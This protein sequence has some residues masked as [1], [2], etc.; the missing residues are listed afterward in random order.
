MGTVV[1][2]A[3]GGL[4]GVEAGGHARFLGI[5]YAA[6]P[7]TDLRW[8][9]PQPPAPWAGV[10][11]A[12]SFGPA[13][14]QPPLPAALARVAVD[15]RQSEDCLYLNV[16][17]PTS[18][19]GRKLPVM[20]WIHG[21]SYIIGSGA[22]PSYD[23][24]AFAR[25]EV[26]CVTLNYRLNHFGFFAHPALT[27]EDPA[28]PLANY[29]ILDQIQA[30]RWI[31]E[32]IAAFGGD[33]ENVTIFG[34]SAGATFTNLLMISPLATG[35]FK[36]AIVQSAPAFQRWRGM[37]HRDG[38]SK[39]ERMGAA[40]AAANG[41]PDADASALRALPAEAVLGDPSRIWTANIGP[42]I[43]GVI[44]P[45]REAETYEAG[46]QH[47]LPL[48]IG[49]NSFEA[50]LMAA[51][52]ASAEAL[53]ASLGLPRAEALATYDPEGVRT[54]DE[55]ARDIFGDRQFV[56]AARFIAKQAA[57]SQPVH[58]YHF[59]YVPETLRGSLPGAPHGSEIPF[60]FETGGAAAMQP[61]AETA[62]DAAM[63]RLMH[64]YW[65]NFARNGD[66]NGPGLPHWP[67]C[68]P[69]TDVCMEFG[70]AG[71]E[72]RSGLHAARLDLAWSVARAKRPQ[73]V[74]AS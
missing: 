39:A 72:V 67:T 23:G 48:I 68:A 16:W 64:R 5:P 59:S 55:V 33:P 15:A 65:V 27:G 37:T 61:Y 73:S 31:R 56:A 10:R 25:D 69:Q 51:Y 3:S 36:R 29:G 62:E 45:D 44:L 8:R 24:A 47:K 2:I 30:L 34:E 66:P 43:D 53:I 40:H 57:S 41:A 19:A 46:R 71:P 12:N 20:M 1:E 74:E 60:V 22:W 6:P 13:C 70:E 14:L 21:G 4:Q 32:N 26:I 7:V 50:S 28:G 9:A 58:H 42:I 49:A 11:A 17:A 38:T 52:P 54:P 18:A 35:L 63:A